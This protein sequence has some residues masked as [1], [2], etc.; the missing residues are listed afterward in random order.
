MVPY[1]FVHCPMPPSSL[2]T[3][4]EK[5]K[6]PHLITHEQGKNAA[7]CYL[8]VFTL[9]AFHSFLLC[10]LF[11]CGLSLSTAQLCLQHC[12]LYNAPLSETQSCLRYSFLY[13]GVPIRQ[14]GCPVIFLEPEIS[15]PGEWQSTASD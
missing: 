1:R 8:Q 14:K 4:A 11:V 9:E 12:L 13:T 15:G 6:F 3:L 7:R 10:P 5:E 2:N